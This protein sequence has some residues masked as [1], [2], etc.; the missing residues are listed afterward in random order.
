ML[1]TP[2][3]IQH[4]LDALFK[5]LRVREAGQ[6]LVLVLR[7]DNEAAEK[8]TVDVG[9]DVAAVIMERPR[10]DRLVRDL[11]RVCPYLAWTNLVRATAV[12]ALRAERP[13][14]V[15]VDTVA[16]SVDVEAMRAEVGAVDVATQ[17]VG[18]LDTYP[19][20]RDAGRQRRAVHI[21]GVKL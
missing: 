20:P 17:P 8:A 21:G 19:R 3:M 7:Q 13:G 9:S 10:S 12:V 18:R 11:V 4:L 14:T 16:Q 2:Q 1:T 5:P 6:V 15:G